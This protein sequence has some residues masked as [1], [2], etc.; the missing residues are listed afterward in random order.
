M[1]P[2][3]KKRKRN[4]WIVLI[5]AAV[6][7]L[8]ASSFFVFFPMEREQEWDAYEKER[9]R[10]DEVLQQASDEEL[11]VVL[12]YAIANQ[13]VP[14]R[15]V[16]PYGYVFVGITSLHRSYLI[17]EKLSSRKD[18]LSKIYPDVQVL[19]E[20]VHWGRQSG[21]PYKN[22]RVSRTILHNVQKDKEKMD[23]QMGSIFDT[24]SM[25]YKYFGTPFMRY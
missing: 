25:A 18:L 1:E 5:V 3:L 9:N 6:L 20:Y 22:N 2:F 7:A 16:D 12:K 10:F 21:Q 15:D 24:S 8:A 4:L 19:D 17:Y 14:N 13:Y 23:A 11:F